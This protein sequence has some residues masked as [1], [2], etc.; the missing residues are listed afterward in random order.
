MVVEPFALAWYELSFRYRFATAEGNAFQDLFVSVM[1][2]A[3]PH[4]FARVQP[5]G[6]KGDLKCDGY[7]T[8]ERRVFACYGPKEF[9]PMPRCVAKVSSDHDGALNHWK[10]HMS[11]W[12]LV[13]ND[14][15]GL[16]AEL[17][18]LLLTLN[19]ADADVEVDHWG[20]PELTLKVRGL[21]TEALVAVFGAVPS[22]REVLALRQDDLRQ[23]LP[24]LAG[25]IAVAPLPVDLR[26]VPPDKLEYNKLSDSARLFLVQG[27]QVSDRV[28]QFFERWDPGL[29]DTIMSAFRHRY[30]EL[31]AQ[32]DL[33][34]D[35][36]LWSL[37]EFAGQGQLTSTREQAAVLALLAYLFESCEIFDRPSPVVTPQ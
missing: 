24:A 17:L 34:P 6:S 12:T 3:H 23:V 33:S 7:L 14:H 5:W 25:A 36:I 16:P 27:M 29:G 15:R 4:D 10:P 8:S 2:R 11:A 20:E 28:R 9:A 22:G 13:H 21:T 1:E 18:Q 37:F 32:G 31:R 35:E 30:Q 19:T 26:P